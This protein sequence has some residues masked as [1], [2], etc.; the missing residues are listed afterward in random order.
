M[1]M[2]ELPDPPVT[3]VTAGGVGAQVRPAAVVQVKVTAPLKPLTEDRFSV[4]LPPFVDDTATLV[5]SGIKVKSES[6]LVMGLPV[7]NVTAEG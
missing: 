7:F 1:F 5:A 6:E 2:L 3:R 4:T